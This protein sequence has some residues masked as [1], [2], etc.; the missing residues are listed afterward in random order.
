[1]PGTA[2]SLRRRS[3][4]VAR[5]RRPIFQLFEIAAQRKADEDNFATARAQFINECFGVGEAGL[6]GSVHFSAKASFGIKLGGGG[7][8][9]SRAQRCFTRSCNFP[10]CAHCST[11]RARRSRSSEAKYGGN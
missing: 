5:A 2:V 9:K 10:G 3:Q 11:M 4:V 7:G 8:V 1:M 6:E